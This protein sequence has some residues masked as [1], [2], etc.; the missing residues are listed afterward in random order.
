MVKI[1][2]DIRKAYNEKLIKAFAAFIAIC[3][4]NNLQYFCCGGTAIGA[5]RHQ[6]MIPWDDDVDVFMPRPDYN[7][8]IKFFKDNSIESYRLILPESDENYYLPYAK[9]S[10]CNTTLIEKEEILCNVGIFIDIFPLDGA[11]THSENIESQLT[12]FRRE[13]NKLMILPKSTFNN[14]KSGFKMIRSFYLRTALN[15]FLLS[16]N[17][18]NKRRKVLEHIHAILETYAYE[19]SEIIGNYGGMWG[20]KEFAPKKWFDGYVEFP[21][22][23]LTVRLPKEYHLLLTQIYGNYMELPPVEKRVTHHHLAYLNLN[24]NTSSDV[25]SK[26]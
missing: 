13:A 16:L 12:K 14:W 24:E 15:E 5:V 6:G 1:T 23:G 21:F 9:M 8:F 10:D 18:T 4:Q 11:P 25:I 7:K 2:P 17:K 26:K 20:K 3:E 19:K 22:E